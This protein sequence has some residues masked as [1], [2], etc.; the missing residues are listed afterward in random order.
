MFLESNFQVLEITKFL[1]SLEN[2]C[3]RRFWAPHVMEIKCFCIRRVSGWNRS[4][5]FSSRQKKSLNHPVKHFV[6][7]FSPHFNRVP[8]DC[9]SNSPH[10]PCRPPRMPSHN[11]LQVAQLW[12]K[13]LY[14]LLEEKARCAV[15]HFPISWS[16]MLRNTFCV[17]L[18]RPASLLVSAGCAD[19]L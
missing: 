19:L 2:I 10:T 9:P 14:H 16:S 5:S 1:T 12:R 8:K 17:C 7:V 3:V 4:L 6:H 15:V 11:Y 13:G 18:K